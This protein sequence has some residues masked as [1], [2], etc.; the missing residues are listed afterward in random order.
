MNWADHI[1]AELQKRIVNESIP[2]IKKCLEKLNIDEIWSRQNEACNSVGNLIL[3]LNG[4]VRQWLLSGMGGAKD[5]RKRDEEFAQ[6]AIIPKSELIKMLDALAVDLIPFK[7]K[8]DGK[9]LLNLYTVQGYPETGI[10]AVIHVI[11]HFSYHTGQIAL[12][13][14]ILKSESL[15]FYSGQ[16]LS[17]V[18]S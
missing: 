3:H 15:E 11:E 10:S 16:D 12:I 18:N 17:Q 1:K 13:T 8:L 4:N 2:R 7:N 6:R 5:T 14:K 9:A